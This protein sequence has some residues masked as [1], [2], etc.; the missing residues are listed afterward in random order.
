MLEILGHEGEE[1]KPKSLGNILEYSRSWCTSILGGNKFP[2]GGGLARH[3]Q[4]VWCH[5]QLLRWVAQ[6]G[7]DHRR[8][9]VR[10][11]CQVL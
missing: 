9:S 10:E 3:Q 7:A 4:V 11:V 6:V 8:L 1:K 5:V 2:K